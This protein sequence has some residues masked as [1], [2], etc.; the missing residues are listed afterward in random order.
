M[1]IQSAFGIG[2][3][4]IYMFGIGPGLRIGFN[5]DDLLIPVMLDMKFAHLIEEKVSL[6]I[7]FALVPNFNLGAGELDVT[8]AT[9]SGHLGVRI[10]YAG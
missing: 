7:G 6:I 9:F 1:R 3:I 5:F 8:S 2:K 10:G 4:G